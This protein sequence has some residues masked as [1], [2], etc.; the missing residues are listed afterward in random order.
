M[1]AYRAMI[2]E[3]RDFVISGW[4]SSFRTSQYAGLVSMRIYAQV[5]HAVIEEILDRPDTRV[6]VAHEPGEFDHQGRPFL[7]GF[8]ATRAGRAPYVYYVYVKAPFRQ[9]RARHGLELGHAAALFTAA[10]IDP[11][12]PFGY[13]CRTSL[14]DRL[15]DRFTGKFPLAQWDPL[16]ARYERP[17]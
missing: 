15:T 17:L 14:S 4:S 7:Y 1:T 8:L 3:D 13:A 6:L 10:G 11:R 5:M 16:P 12:R 9:G 2:D